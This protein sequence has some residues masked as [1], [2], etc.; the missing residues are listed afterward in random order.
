MESREF[1]RDTLLHAMIAQK[2]L[3]EKAMAQLGGDDFHWSPD[4]QSNSIAIIV[5][6]MA[7]NMRSRWTDFLTSDGEKPWRN[8]DGEFVDD[9]GAKDEIMALWE[10]GWACC[11]DALRQLSDDDLRR[12]VSVGGKE[13]PALDAVLGQLG[14]YGQHVGQIVYL[15]KLRLGEGW[16][17]VSIPRRPRLK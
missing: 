7:G 16:E 14:H 1:F 9:L 5:K 10:E 15:A 4:G 2:L 12:I 3:A 11:F 17:T 13:R 8:R 6:H